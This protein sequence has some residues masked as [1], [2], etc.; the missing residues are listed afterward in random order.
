[1][2]LK[3]VSML[4]VL[5]IILI[6]VDIYQ[7][8]APPKQLRWVNQLQV[9]MTKKQVEQIIGR[10]GGQSYP[11]HTV[12]TYAAPGSWSH[13]KIFFNATNNLYV[14]YEFDY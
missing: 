10:P 5:I 3:T 12:W 7:F 6:G 4:V 2:F 13:L 14:G 1:M 9:G 8:N 11:Y